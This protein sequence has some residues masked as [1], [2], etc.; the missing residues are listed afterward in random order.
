MLLFVQHRSC[1]TDYEAHIRKGGEALSIVVNV[2]QSDLIPVECWD[3]NK[4]EWTNGA[5]IPRVVNHADAF[6]FTINQ[7][8]RTSHMVEELGEAAKVVAACFDE[9][10]VSDKTTKGTVRF[11]VYGRERSHF[12][13]A[14]FTRAKYFAD[15]NMTRN[16]LDAMRPTI[17]PNSP[18]LPDDRKVKQFL[19]MP[20][21]EN[22]LFSTHKDKS[23]HK[24]WK[25]SHPAL[26]VKIPSECL[27]EGSYNSSAAAAEQMVRIA[28]DTHAASRRA[29]M[30]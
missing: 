3:K 10:N 22:A 16:V 1:I 20:E 24:D 21:S 14:F 4:L 17:K 5:T 13:N 11:P 30:N 27:I 28:R 2:H 18:P 7:D 19:A 15:K 12:T 6:R 29:A 8:A 9:A 23:R 25:L 26:A